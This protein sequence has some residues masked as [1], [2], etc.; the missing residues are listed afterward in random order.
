MKN[1]KQKNR[2]SQNEKTIQRN[3]RI[4]SGF[5]VKASTQVHKA[6]NKYNRKVKYKD[7]QD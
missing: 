5:G 2:I 3:V 1:K 4:E 6:K 7:V